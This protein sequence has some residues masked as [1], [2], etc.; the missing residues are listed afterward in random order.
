MNCPPRKILHYGPKRP[1]Q[2]DP[3]FAIG[4]WPLTIEPKLEHRKTLSR[5]PSLYTLPPSSICLPF[6]FVPH[7]KNQTKTPRC[8]LSLSRI[9]CHSLTHSLKSAEERR[10]QKMIL[11]LI[12]WILCLLINFGLLAIVFYAVFTILLFYPSKQ[13]LTLFHSLFPVFFFSFYL[14]AIINLARNS[15]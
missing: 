7:N 8:S 5:V 15:C 14:L 3:L 13:T 1:I 6:F 10:K 11:N 9:L 12:F 4:Y 2:R